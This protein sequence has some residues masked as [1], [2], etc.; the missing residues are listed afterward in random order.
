MIDTRAGRPV[1]YSCAKI[2]AKAVLIVLSMMIIRDQVDSEHLIIS[3]YLSLQAVH[4]LIQS[5]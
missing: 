3:A 2:P 1:A 5:Q 4:D